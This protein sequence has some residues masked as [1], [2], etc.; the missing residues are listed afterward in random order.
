MG[1]L[2]DWISGAPFFQ[3][4]AKSNGAAFVQLLGTDG[5]TPASS[6]NPVPT[7]GGSSGGGVVAP[8]TATTTSTAASTASQQVHAA[9]ANRL[10][11]SFANTGTVGTV[12]L[13]YGTGAASATNYTVSLPP[14]ST[15]NLPQ[16]FLG[17]FQAVWSSTAAGAGPLLMTELTT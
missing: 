16:N 10:G 5:V 11:A 1:A 15:W 2:Y 14:G 12:Y 3:R 4:G 7:S 17:A 6:S 8:G 9:N 13:L